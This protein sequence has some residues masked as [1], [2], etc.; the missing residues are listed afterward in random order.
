MK[1]AAVRLVIRIRETGEDVWPELELV[2]LTI[3]RRVYTNR[4]MDYVARTLRRAVKERNFICK[5]AK[6]CTWLLCYGGIS[7]QSSKSMNLILYRCV[8]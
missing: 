5:R 3:P 8:A 4:H 7:L 1:Q 6:N 2:R